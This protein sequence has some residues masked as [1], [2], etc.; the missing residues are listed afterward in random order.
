[1]SGR[2]SQ[3]RRG[4]V[5]AAAPAAPHRPPSKC[6]TDLR[7]TSCTASPEAADRAN[8]REQLL[9]A[10]WFGRLATA[11]SDRR[12]EA[13]KPGRCAPLGC[14]ECWAPRIPVPLGHALQLSRDFWTLFPIKQVRNRLKPPSFEFH[15]RAARPRPLG[16]PWPAPRMVDL[17]GKTLY[18]ALGVE[19]TASQ[20]RSGCAAQ[21]CCLFALTPCLNAGF[22]PWSLI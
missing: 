21:R 7:A 15:L 9:A 20:V 19:R 13:P 17:K 14:C 12:C 16:P 6:A 11:T 8:S 18:E 4:G 1:M 3:L 5:R 22:P 10:W 2:L